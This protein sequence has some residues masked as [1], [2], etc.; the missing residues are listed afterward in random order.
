VTHIATD[1]L[2]TIDPAIQI[3]N[4]TIEKMDGIDTISLDLKVP[5]QIVNT[6]TEVQQQDLAK[7]LAR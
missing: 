6:I 1:F 4:I 3:E 5:Q 2:T 7:L